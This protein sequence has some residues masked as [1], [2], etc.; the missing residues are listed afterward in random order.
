MIVDQATAVLPIWMILSAA[1][2]FLVGE[3]C[4]DNHRHRKYLEQANA[5]LR[6][7]LQ[8]PAACAEPLHDEL[9]HQ[10]GVLHDIH[11]RLVAVTK[12]LE[13]PTA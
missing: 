3:A 5:E 2:G 7:R 6:D 10:R 11:R 8:Q 12:C 1:F 4:G 13:K 9:K